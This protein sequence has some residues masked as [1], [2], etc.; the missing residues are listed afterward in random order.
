MPIGTISKPIT[1]PIRNLIQ[2]APLLLRGIRKAAL[3]GP[4]QDI[5]SAEML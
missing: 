1:S 4:E 2:F 3:S 5:A